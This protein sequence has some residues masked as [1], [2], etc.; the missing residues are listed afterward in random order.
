MVKGETE[1]Q[2]FVCVCRIIGRSR[3]RN[4]LTEINCNKMCKPLFDVRLYGIT[5]EANEQRLS[6]ASTVM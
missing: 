3:V 5:D 6:E 1:L 2:L 4:A